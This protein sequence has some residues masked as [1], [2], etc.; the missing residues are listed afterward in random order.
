MFGQSSHARV[1]AHAMADI[2]RRMQTLERRLERLGGVA[3]RG[4]AGVLSSVG[5]S[6]ERIGETIGAALAVVADRFRG[7]AR[8]VGGEA[9]RFGHEAARLGNDT[10]RRI[11][12][13]AEHHPLMML[14]VAAG[15][16]IL[17][18]GLAGRRS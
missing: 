6:S 16:G 1:T 14:A 2:E 9:S 18:A 10:L 7:G 5:L 15:V 11:S 17:I 8:S 4:P 12:S 3:R 13:G